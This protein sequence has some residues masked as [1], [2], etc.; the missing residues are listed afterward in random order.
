MNKKKKSLATLNEEDSLSSNS[1]QQEEAVKFCLMAQE[2][3]ELTLCSSSSNSLSFNSLQ[4]EYSLLLEMYN[5]VLAKNKVLKNVSTIKEKECNDLKITY[6]D[7][8]Q[9]VEQKDKEIQT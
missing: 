2:E 9:I 1:S 4:D 7:L 6:D 3:N 8:E 5:K